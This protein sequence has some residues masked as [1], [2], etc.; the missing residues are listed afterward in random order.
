MDVESNFSQVAPPVFDGENYDAWAIKMGA[1]LEALDL[2][3]AIEEDYEILPLPENPTM[4]Q[5]KSYKEKKTRKAKAKSCL[6]AGVSATLFTRIMT[7][8]TAKEIWEYLKKEYAGDERIRG[9]QVLNLMREFE[10]QK[11]KESETIKEYSDRLLAIV[12]K[13]RLLGTNFLDCR[14]IEKIL[15]TVPERYE[16]SIT[17]LENT[18]DLSKITLA[19]VLHALQAQ[20]QRRLMRQDQVVEGALPAKHHSG[21]KNFKKH[22]QTSGENTTYKGKGKKKNYPPCEH[23]GKLGHPPF[24]CW[25]RPDAKC[26]KCNQLGHEA[27]ICGSKQHEVNAQVVEQ[28]DE[29]HIFSASIF[30]AKSNSESEVRDSPCSWKTGLSIGVMCCK[31]SIGGDDGS[32]GL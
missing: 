2:W 31:V 30:S 12:N 3:E 8:K 15:V 9:M 28:D 27:V 4:T 10:L 13:V 25:K 20:E 16:A 17:T 23:C 32:G 7:L 24:R 1:Y 19:E 14:I 18:K 26:N 21:K 11:M 29:D 22:K 5:M 6:F